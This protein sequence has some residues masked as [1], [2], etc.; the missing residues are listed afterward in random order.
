MNVTY[1]NA[2]TVRLGVVLRR[3]PGVTR[4]AKWI[5]KAVAVLPGAPD[6]SWK[7]MRREGDVTEYHAATLPLTLYTSDTEAYVHELQARAPSV[8]VVLRE[9][10]RGKDTPLE[11]AAVTVSPYEAQDYCDSG[12]EIVEK[13]PMPPAVLAWVG[14]F[15]DAHHEEEEFIKRRRNKARTDRVQDGIGDARIAQVTDVYRAPSR[16]VPGDAQ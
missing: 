4:W 15:V 10:P 7:E 11:V 12:E 2:Q 16:R 13:V 6:A 14:A 5:W 3:S 8:Y 1:P 9:T